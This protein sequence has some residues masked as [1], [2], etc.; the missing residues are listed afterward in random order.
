[1]EDPAVER[2]SGCPSLA[3]FAPAGE[4]RVPCVEFLQHCCHID[5]PGCDLPSFAAMQ[6][7]LAG[8]DGAAE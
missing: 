4:A 3:P 7:H 5:S 1:M 8:V 6:K 2:E